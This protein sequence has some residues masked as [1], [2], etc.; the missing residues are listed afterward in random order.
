MP[1]HANP[2]YQISVWRA[3]FINPT[4]QS[5]YVQAE[6]RKASS[7]GRRNATTAAFG[8]LCLGFIFFQQSRKFDAVT[9]FRFPFSEGFII[10]FVG[11]FV[12]LL[13]KPPWMFRL[14]AILTL[15]FLLVPIYS[16]NNQNVSWATERD[17]AVTL[18]SEMPN[19]VT[20]ITALSLGGVQ[21]RAGIAAL[22]IIGMRIFGNIFHQPGALS[23]GGYKVVLRMMWTVG[24]STFVQ[25][26]RQIRS[27][28]DWVLLQQYMDKEA[29]ET[30]NGPPSQKGDE[31]SSLD[32]KGKENGS[33]PVSNPGAPPRRTIRTNHRRCNCFRNLLLNPPFTDKNAEE[34]FHRF[35]SVFS[36]KE[37]I[38]CHGSNILSCWTSGAILCYL[39]Q[40]FPSE[41]VS[42][43]VTIPLLSIFAIIIKSLGV[44]GGGC[45]GAQL[46][47]FREQMSSMCCYLLV[48][49]FMI[50]D[51]STRYR[52]L[53]GENAISRLEAGLNP[54]TSAFTSIL[55]I[56]LTFIL[57]RFDFEA[58]RGPFAV[59]VL[60]MEVIGL[61]LGAWWQGYV[62]PH[63]FAA[64]IPSLFQIVHAEAGLRRHFLVHHPEF[65]SGAGVN[66][67]S[68][69]AR[70]ADEIQ[71]EPAIKVSSVAFEE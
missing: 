38:L 11:M 58:F 32:N 19:T 15:A 25:W 31:K 24:L 63:Y 2:E 10:L 29:N 52:Q 49:F 56:H 46:H 53:S 66:G 42:L 8:L 28:R 27:M 16:M 12:N 5:E 59:F 39:L 13:L 55:L 57:A 33:A 61:C 54:K 69:S 62:G 45:Q 30:G 50:W 44:F 37:Q 6:A 51:V 65:G 17:M 36:V 48:D 18:A 41:A 9:L 1:P 7:T 3:S 4:T 64:S 23:Q 26:R 67:G 34:T 20:V 47:P 35:C 21:Q 43:F 71:S 60:V 40:G 14:T 70:K 22:Y 68:G